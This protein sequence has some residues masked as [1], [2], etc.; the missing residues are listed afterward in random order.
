MFLAEKVCDINKRL[1]ALKSVSNI[2][3]WGAGV[4]T[5]KLFEYT[6]MLAYDV[7][8]IVDMDEQ[9]QGNSCFT[10]TVQ[11]PEKVVWDYVGAVVISVSGHK[12]QIMDT[13]I[14][15]FKFMGRIITLYEHNECTPFY[16]LYDEKTPA[17]R[18]FG[19]YDS[20]DE[21]YHDCKGYEDAEILSTVS[22]A[23]DKVIKGEAAW[24][25]D[26]YLFYKQKYVY[27]ICATILKCAVQNQNK[28][29]R[30][31]DIGGGL[32]STYLQN[33][34]YLSDIRNL[35]YIVAEQA[36]FADYGHRN[37]QDETLKFIKSTDDW[38]KQGKFDIILLSASLQ[39]I[40]QYKE[41]IARIIAAQP[42]YII[43]DRIMVGNRMRICKETVPEYIYESSYPIRIFTEE[44][45]EKFFEPDYRMIERDTSSVPEN[46]YFTD[47]RADSRYYVYEFQK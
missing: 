24:E 17:V 35:E 46:A 39:Y 4:H 31:L 23:V 14:K 8:G 40:A 13:L 20:W 25:R 41:I 6:D 32:G 47:G 28:S 44:Q 1:K 18:Y 26:G 22:N 27:R 34:G 7:Q 42:H 21:A 11:S 45:V 12:T 33:R 16:M 36:H 37:M 9:K 19:D 38:E 29:V 10:F 43:L 15:R 2:V 5:C 30:I 3:I